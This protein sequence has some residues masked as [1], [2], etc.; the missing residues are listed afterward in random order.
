MIPAHQC[1]KCGC[2]RGNNPNCPECIE[3]ASLLK[4]YLLAAT[5]IGFEKG[6]EEGVKHTIRKEDKPDA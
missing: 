2:L 6:F 3:F 1:P 5:K 4:R